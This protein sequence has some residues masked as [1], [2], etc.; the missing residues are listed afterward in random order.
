MIATYILLFI[1]A[2]GIAVIVIMSGRLVRP[3]ML[4]AVYRRLPED[5]VPANQLADSI[6]EGLKRE[7]VAGIFFRLYCRDRIPI[8]MMF[9]TLQAY[10]FAECD[11]RPDR[12][13]EQAKHTLLAK[14]GYLSDVKP[15]AKVP[16]RTIE[17][18]I[19]ALDI[20]QVGWRKRVSGRKPG[21]LEFLPT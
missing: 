11:A 21:L 1:P 14:L 20:P 17:N 4:Q 5:Y 7:M 2:A 3:Y 18:A 8:L 6:L 19:K 12:R 9:D 15:D 10:G 13:I 16:I